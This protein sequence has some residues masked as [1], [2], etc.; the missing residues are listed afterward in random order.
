MT[1]I[2]LASNRYKLRDIL[3]YNLNNQQLE[4][5]RFEVV[6]SELGLYA[7]LSGDEFFIK[8]AIESAKFLLSNYIKKTAP[9]FHI[10]SD[11][12]DLTIIAYLGELDYTE[13]FHSIA[14]SAKYKQ[15]F[16][17]T[18]RL[19][20]R[21]ICE[22]EKNPT[23]QRIKKGHIASEKAW[24]RIVEEYNAEQVFNLSVTLDHQNSFILKKFILPMAFLLSK[25]KEEEKRSEYLREILSWGDSNL[26]RKKNIIFERK[27]APPNT[28]TISTE[29]D[30]SIG[31]DAVEL[32]QDEVSAYYY[33]GENSE[34][35]RLFEKEAFARV[36]FEGISSD[37]KTVENSVEGRIWSQIKSLKAK[38]KFRYVFVYDV[39]NVNFPMKSVE[40][41]AV[42]S[43]LEIVLKDITEI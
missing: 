36:Y 5:L 39:E 7:L 24:L 17:K 25:Q 28:E 2:S 16:E 33:F 38:N 4:K 1:W 40:T 13:I 41:A 26:N 34:I 32:N 10:L 11:V 12:I 35:L 27:Q 42:K 3:E 8:R 22:I 14:K 31:F 30:K 21:R 19:V 23:K 6:S 18:L 9:S 29:K 20:V 15:D 43:G 37:W